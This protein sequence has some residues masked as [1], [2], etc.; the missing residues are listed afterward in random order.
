MP[1]TTPDT[2]PTVATAGVDDSHV[3]P[4]VVLVSA[5][6][7]PMHIA[8]VPVTAAGGVFTKTTALVKQPVGNV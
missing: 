2:E 7:A 4:V 3:P 1:V 5:V 8:D 6:V